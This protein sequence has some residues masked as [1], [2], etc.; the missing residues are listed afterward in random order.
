[1]HE[2]DLYTYDLDSIKHSFSKIGVELSDDQTRMFGRY[3][4]MLIE[5]NKVMNLTTI[6]EFNDVVIKH[7]VDSL[8]CVLLQP[9][10]DISSQF[11]SGASVIDVGTGAGFPGIP[12]KIV[13]PEVKLTLLDSLNKR[14]DFLRDVCTELKLS[15]VSFIHARAE[16]A[17]HDKNLRDS[18][19]FCVSRAVANLSTLSEYCLPFVKTHGFFLSYKSE[20]ADEEISSAKN[21]LAVLGGSISI[22]KKFDLPGTDYSRTLVLIKKDRGTPKIY[23]R[24]AGTPSKKPL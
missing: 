4:E 10:F 15:D 24:K 20:K 18:F 11:R 16:D 22:E 21:A 17:A 3:Y 1:M 6:T 5:K 14:V 8:S 13:F 19:N 7:F 9:E 23:P 12:L 2:I